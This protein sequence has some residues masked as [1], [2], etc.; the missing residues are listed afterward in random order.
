MSKE[1][2]LA[3]VGKFNDEQYGEF[4]FNKFNASEWAESWSRSKILKKLDDAFCHGFVGIH[5]IPSEYEGCIEKILHTYFGT[6]HYI[7][8]RIC[9]K[10]G[11]IIIEPNFRKLKVPPSKYIS[12]SY[13]RE[14]TLHALQEDGDYVS[15]CY[16]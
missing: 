12:K 3:I 9:E 6:D 5:F 10:H 13:K 16:E 11:F 1:D 2:I 4:L 14:K 7:C 8:Y 15:F